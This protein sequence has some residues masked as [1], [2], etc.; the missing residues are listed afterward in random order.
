MRVAHII[1]S[2]AWGGAQK[3]LVT[4][5]E[6][7]RTSNVDVTIITL[8]ADKKGAPFT[9][10][11]DVTFPNSMTTV[12]DYQRRFQDG[13]DWV[14]QL[15]DDPTF[16]TPSELR[17]DT[18]SRTV[19]LTT[20]EG[21]VTTVDM[22]AKGRII[23]IASAGVEPITIVRDAGG[24]IV[25]VSQ[26]AGAD[27][28]RVTM[29][30]DIT[31]FLD[32]LTAHLGLSSSMTD[33]DHDAIGRTTSIEGPDLSVVSVDYDEEHRVTGLTPPARPAHEFDYNVAGLLEQYSP[34]LAHPQQAATPLAFQYDVDR[35]L[36]GITPAQGNVIDYIYAPFT[37]RVMQVSAGAAS[38]ELDH[39]T[40]GRVEA[41]IGPYGAMELTFGYDGPLLTSETWSGTIPASVSTTVDARGRIGSRSI[42]GGSTVAFTYDGDNL[43][44]QAGLSSITR[45]PAS[46]RIDAVDVDLVGQQLSYNAFGETQAS[47]YDHDGTPLFSYTLVH[48]QL[49]RLV[50]ESHSVDGGPADVRTYEY[51]DA[52]RLSRVEQGTVW[53]EYD[54]DAN[55]NRTSMTT[56]GGSTNATFDD[57]DRIETMGGAVF[58]SDDN[59][60][61]ISVDHGAGDEWTYEFDVLGNLLSATL[62]GG[63]GD[64]VEYEVDARGR[65]VAR[66][67]D[68]VTTGILWSNQL[69]PIAQ[70]DDQGVVT[71][72]YVY[73]SRAHVP[74][75]MVR[76]GATYRLVTD[77]RGSVR[78]VVDVATGTSHQDIEY[79]PWGEIMSDSNPGFQLFGY[80][81]GVHD[82]VTGLVLFGARTYDPQSGRW[83]SRDPLLHRGGQANFYT[84]VDGDPANFIDETGLRRRFGDIVPW[85]LWSVRMGYTINST[86]GLILGGAGL[87]SGG[88]VD[89][90]N[91]MLIFSG[92]ALNFTEWGVF[93]SRAFTAGAVLVK[94][95]D[96]PMADETNWQPVSSDPAMEWAFGDYDLPDN[97]GSPELANHE[98]AHALQA[99]LFGLA[100]FPAVGVNYG[101]ARLRGRTATTFLDD[102]ANRWARF[103]D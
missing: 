34:P 11:I 98:A 64:V 61:V 40:A 76:G 37:H 94:R 9:S 89:V 67:F 51:N 42:N 78:R 84:Y 16:M 93:D 83:L 47:S 35:R 77:V 75:Y 18:V 14:E 48:D 21:R 74:D 31:G 73:G 2:L 62:P 52:G 80:A 59:G 99:R 36:Q 58:T 90:E 6:A 82:P 91:G 103:F 95:T 69:D 102:W 44:T 41:A 70:T 49:G 29:T 30:R 53:V 54:Y 71:T 43:L 100:Y 55:G 3:L 20:A 39:D 26:G 85:Q 87:V 23:G 1:D 65:R 72:R 66:T 57:Q 68:G 10:Q 50:S 7:A 45:D 13:D 8:Q 81:G 15:D 79:G 63:G 46:G 24:K 19:T 4:F 22:D 5:A 32:E 96:C 60:N 88:S 92:G 97:L 101:V 33:L 38:V 86:V 28:R 12:T 27:E 56:A 25:E 17:Y